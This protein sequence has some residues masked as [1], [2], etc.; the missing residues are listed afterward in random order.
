MNNYNYNGQQQQQQQQQQE[1]A[2]AF[3]VGPHCHNGKILLGLFLEETCSVKAADGTYEK[4]F[5]GQPLPHSSTSIIESKCMSCKVP[6]ENDMAQQNDNNYVVDE[7]NYYYNNGEM[8]QGQ[9]DWQQEQEQEPDEVTE[10][11]GQIYEASAKCEKS[12]HVYGMYPDTR[13]CNYIAS[14]KQEGAAPLSSLRSVPVTP[15]VLAAVFAATTVMFAGLSVYLHKQYK[16]SQ[17]GLVHG[18]MMA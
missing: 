11:C 13:A 9:Q 16:R 10:A 5:Y 4:M 7:N 6:K 1:M 12:L 18:K 3:F 14:L 17:V 2:N 8:Q 15:T